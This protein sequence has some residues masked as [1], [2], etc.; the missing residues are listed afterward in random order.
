[1]RAKEDAWTTID[2]AHVEARA[3]AGT[4]RRPPAAS[5]RP[6]EHGPPFHP[7]LKTQRKRRR[8]SVHPTLRS[9]NLFCSSPRGYRRSISAAPA[10]PT[11]PHSTPPHPQETLDIQRK[12][13]MSHNAAKMKPRSRAA[14][15]ARSPSP[16]PFLPRCFVGNLV[17][18][19]Q[20]G[21]AS[22]RTFTIDRYRPLPCRTAFAF[23]ARGGAVQHTCRP[24]PS[25]E[26]KYE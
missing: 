23:L 6:G 21:H 16:L 13:T 15:R 22:S 10:H 4:H 14:L 3:R 9:P 11:R 25:H 7:C 20:I 26:L 2:T 18:S 24:F 1:M 12:K 19:A 8:R 17:S 5:D